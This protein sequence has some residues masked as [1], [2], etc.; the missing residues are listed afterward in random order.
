MKKLLITSIIANTVIFGITYSFIANMSSIAFAIMIYLLPLIYNV[1]ATW[2][3]SKK[4]SSKQL[5]QLFIGL[6][7]ISTIFYY[8]FGLSMKNNSMWE[9]FINKNTM[10]SGS[11]SFSVGHNLISPSQIIFIIALYGCIEF[12]TKLVLKNKKLEVI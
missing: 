6:P 8:V 3:A 5:N 1:G 10:T 2:F 11:V 9:M 7:T 4:L 12:L